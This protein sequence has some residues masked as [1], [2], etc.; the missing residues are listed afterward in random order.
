[1]KKALLVALMG[2]MTIIAAN[3]AVDFQNIT[4]TLKDG[5]VIK[6]DASQLDHV[7]YVGGEFGQ[8]GAVG[9]KLYITA[10]ISEDYLY[11]QITSIVYDTQESTTTT[12]TRITSTEQLE[13]G[14]KY[15]IVYEATPA[16]MGAVNSFG[17]SITG[18]DNFTL[19]NG[20]IELAEESNAKILTLG[21][22]EG[23][24]TF[25]ID[26]TYLNYSSG[27]SLTTGDTNNTWTISF[28]N[29]NAIIKNSSNTSYIIQYNNT[30][31]QYRFSCYKGTQQPIQLYKEGTGSGG[32]STTDNNVNANW[33]IPGM[34]IPKS[35]ADPSFT[36]QSTDDYSWRLEFPHI[37][38]SS[39]NQRV[40][41]ATADY[42]IT[43]SIEWDN[44]KI[45]NRWTCYTMCAKNNEDNTKRQNSFK[46]DPAVTTSPSNSYTQSSTY[47][48]GHLCPSAD[49]LC[50]EEQNMQTFFMTNMQP[51]YQN[52][53]GNSCWATL[54]GYVRTKWQ[55]TNNTDTLYV[56]KAAT[57]ESVTLN[58]SSVSG[59]I[60][61][62]TDGSGQILVVPKYFYMAFLYYTKSTNSYKAFALWTEQKQS[63]NEAPSSVIT[64][65]IS[66]DELEL[67]T[68]I[69]FF[70]NLPDDIE[71]TVEATATYW[72]NSQ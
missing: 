5:Q 4:I 1:M 28:D 9:I 62:T 17:A 48:R 54:E 51:Q 19:S 71:S 37:N 33:N 58:G 34:N 32:S 53:N 15:L 64:N 40:V 13:A 31:N 59:I 45:A 44:N 61:T 22:S 35:K 70:C 41:K 66:I 11:S 27:N 63:N 18:P 16:V 8:E 36:N 21:G 52:H 20:V 12:F 43:Y 47:S 23:A 49:R 14:K 42:G 25:S 55:P 7:T 56:I 50:S 38:T 69:D 68:G 24:W 39:G 57:I 29:N 72:D 30:A 6:R 2:L 60:T 67:R 65:R 3:A 46:A 10:T 26:N